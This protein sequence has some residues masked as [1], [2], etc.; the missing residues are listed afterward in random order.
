MKRYRGHDGA[1]TGVVEHPEGDLVRVDEVRQV[2][3]EY[4]DAEVFLWE[5]VEGETRIEH[6]AAASAMDGVLMALF[7]EEQQ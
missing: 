1:G 7:P 2:I 5:H 3:R 6:G 4:Q